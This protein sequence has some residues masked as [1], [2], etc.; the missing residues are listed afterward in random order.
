MHH[1]SLDILGLSDYGSRELLAA[2]V[3]Y[4][5]PPFLIWRN[6]LQSIKMHQ[7]AIES[8]KQTHV[9]ANRCLHFFFG[10]QGNMVMDLVKEGSFGFTHI[11]GPQLHS[12]EY[13]TSTDW[14][15]TKN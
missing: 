13:T 8:V 4:H 3:F 6:M 2:E 14:Q 7:R 5:Y 12:I 9:L 10:H 1:S 11:V 15:V